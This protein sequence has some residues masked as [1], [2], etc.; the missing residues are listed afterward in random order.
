MLKCQWQKTL[1]MSS[2]CGR[3]WIA[4]RWKKS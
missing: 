1:W 2:S 3:R 4:E